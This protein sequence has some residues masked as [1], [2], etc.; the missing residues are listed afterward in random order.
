M[1]EGRICGS[2]MNLRVIVQDQQDH[3]YIVQMHA[4][5]HKIKASSVGMKIGQVRPGLVYL[6][7]GL[8]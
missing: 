7:L 1:N 8:L 5:P 3:H 6:G 4:C 2:A